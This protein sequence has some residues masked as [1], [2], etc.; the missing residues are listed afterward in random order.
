MRRAWKRPEIAGGMADELDDDLVARHA[1]RE[2]SGRD[3]Q[4]VAAEGS[5]EA[6]PDLTVG[7]VGADD[8]RRAQGPAGRLE[9][10]GIVRSGDI[11]DASGDHISA[12]V[13]RGAEQTSIEVGTAHD[14]ERGAVSGAAT[15]VV[16]V[17]KSV[18]ERHHRRAAGRR[19]DEARRA[20][21]NGRQI[22]GG[23]RAGDERQ[24]A[25][26]DAAPTRLLARMR[27]VDDRDPGPAPRER[28][29]GPRAGRPRADNGDIV[30]Y[31]RGPTLPSTFRQAQVD[32]ERRRRVAA[33]ADDP[34]LDSRRS[35]AQSMT[36]PAQAI[37]RNH[38]DTL[39]A[40]IDT[41][42]G[43]FTVGVFQDAAWAQKGLDALK[44]AGFP[45]ESLTI[46]AKEATDVA[47]LFERTFGHAGAAA[48]AGLG[49]RHPRSRVARRGAAGKRARSDEAGPGR[50]DAPR[51][52][53]GARRRHLRNVD[54]AGRRAGRHSHRAAR[55]RRARDSA[56][57]RRWQRGHRRLVRDASGARVR[58]GS[59]LEDQ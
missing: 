41:D 4:L 56:L 8:E 45:S 36:F 47:A 57:L 14:D 34:D 19:V 16:P 20:D 6:A 29:R 50:H 18:V 25:S 32:P 59:R 1:V 51:R 55:R 13:A 22:R 40:M 44:Q 27:A 48:R 7:A 26:R 28:V 10:D 21:D 12:G 46:I 11:G 31:S 52:I 58:A 33:V 42:M 53:P 38:R 23:H 54:R 15:V 39:H 49:R 5:R 30:L 17:T 24:R 9:G 35:S 3:R 43:L 37:V 2:E